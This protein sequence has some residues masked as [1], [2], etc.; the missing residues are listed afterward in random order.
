MKKKI[1]I[2]IL[3]ILSITNFGLSFHQNMTTHNFDEKA[4]KDNIEYLSSDQF[5]GRM[6]GTF[7]NELAASYIRTQF[8]KNDIEPF[9]GNYYEAFNTIFP[10]KVDG[11]PYLKVLNSQ[12]QIVKQF[13]YNTDFKEDTLSFAQNHVISNKSSLFAYDDNILR[14]TNNKNNYIFYVP[15]NNKLLFR[16]SF[17]ADCKISMLIE[18]TSSTIKDM[19]CCLTSGDTIDCFIPYEESKIKINNVIGIIKGKNPSLSPLVIGAHFDHMGI[20]FSN[21]IY[22]G[23]LDNAS[24]ISFVLEMSKYIKSLGTPDR[25]IIFAAFNAEEFGLLGSDTFAKQY[26][27]KLQGS[28]VFNFDMIGSNNNVPLCIMGAKTDTKNT[29]LIHSIS[30]IC[31]SNHINFSYLFED[32]SDHSPFRKLGIDAVTFCDNDM[33]RI[34]TPNDKAEFISTSAIKRCYNVSS[35][36]ILG[37]AYKDNPWLLYNKYIW[38]ISLIS[39][40]IL[41]TALVVIHLKATKKQ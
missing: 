3:L 17:D 28:K 29:P 13:S 23:A 9:M 18:V 8:K 12:G 35:K 36:E 41:A 19:Q 21:N 33:T 34:H 5:T 7:S 27:K 25:D 16:S 6:A 39:S 40:L 14:I 26:S 38:I 2:S 4:V 10:K 1:A 30:A 11:S 32:A 15:D 20:D 24:G 37:L 31:T 22:H